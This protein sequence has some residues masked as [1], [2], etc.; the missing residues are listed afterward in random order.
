MQH[1]HSPVCK[2]MVIWSSMM[3]TSQMHVAVRVVQAVIVTMT[4]MMQL[5]NMVQLTT[6]TV[7]TSKDPNLLR[8]NGHKALVLFRIKLLAK[9]DDIFGRTR[10]IL[11]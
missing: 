1:R 8:V 9:H 10:S 7:L 2:V 4:D 3:N 11:S 5:Q 6:V